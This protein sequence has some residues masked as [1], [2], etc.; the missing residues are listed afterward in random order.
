[1]Y[2]F[3]SCD[4]CKFSIKAPTEEPCSNCVHNAMDNFKPKSNADRIR[5]MSDEELAE[6]LIDHHRY[7][8]EY[9]IG[10]HVECHEGL[11]EWLKSE[12]E[13]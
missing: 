9:C 5:E 2:E 7:P 3:E 6:F 8:C 13:E 4:K 11:A 12:V 10:C 1:M